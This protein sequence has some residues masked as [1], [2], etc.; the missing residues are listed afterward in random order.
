MRPS[1]LFPYAPILLRHIS[2]RTQHVQYSSHEPQK[3]EDDQPPRPR[4]RRHVEDVAYARPGDNAG[5]KLARQPKR[6]RIPIGVPAFGFSRLLSV[7]FMLGQFA[8]Q[9]IETLLQLVRPAIVRSTVFVFRRTHIG[10][11][12]FICHWPF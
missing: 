7:A 6:L 2:S 8:L 5:Y 9:T 12:R 10:V 11:V 1:S 3:E 4:A